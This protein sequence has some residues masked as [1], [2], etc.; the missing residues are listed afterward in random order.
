MNDE[1]IWVLIPLILILGTLTGCATITKGTEDTVQVQIGNCGEKI[2]CTA[3]NK[4]GS[5]NFTAPGP[6][7]FKK[8]DDP[9]TITCDDG[10]E[11]LSVQIVP[12]RGSMAWG[13]IIFGG[14]IGGGVDSGTDAHWD[15][16][17]SLVVA[18]KYC[19]GEILN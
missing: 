14:I 4:K 5:W 13:N 6:V 18:R 7:R 8:S 3:T 9:L 17:D 16:T 11:V 12:V 10:P 1:K 19:N 2:Q 15:T